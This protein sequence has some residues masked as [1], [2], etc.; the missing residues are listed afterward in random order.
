MSSGPR[1]V[2]FTGTPNLSYSGTA[3]LAKVAVLVFACCTQE[4]RRASVSGVPYR[5]KAYVAGGRVRRRSRA[6]GIAIAP[7]VGFMAQ[8]RAAL[9][10]ARVSRGR[11]DGIEP[12]RLHVPHR[13]EAVRAPLPGIPDGV[14]EAE[15]VGLEGIYRRDPGEAILTGIGIRKHPLPGVAHVAAFRSEFVAPRV[16]LLIEA[17]TRG[18]LPLRFGWKPV[19]GPSAVSYRIAPRDVDGRVVRPVANRCVGAFGMRPVRA[20]HAPPPRCAR[21]RRPAE[22]P[23]HMIAKDERPA[24]AFGLGAISGLAHEFTELLVGD[25]EL[26]NVESAQSDSPHRAFAVG[27]DGLRRL[28]PHM[29]RSGFDADHVFERTRC[30]AGPDAGCVDAGGVL[31]E[32]LLG[33]SATVLVAWHVQLEAA[34]GLASAGTQR[35]SARSRNCATARM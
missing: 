8:I 34:S 35:M 17:P 22:R 32:A 3:Y 9:H 2:L 24:I 16:S 4:E 6:G 29:E 18:I 14:V 5:A 15:A 10:H 28:A 26:R 20:I 11:P 23:R 12:A 1:P 30:N 19:A 21:Q 7:A 27:G 25:G 33:G 31:R 13:I